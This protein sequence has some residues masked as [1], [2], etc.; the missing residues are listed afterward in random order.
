MGNGKYM[1]YDVYHDTDSAF[2]TEAFLIRIGYQ[3]GAG[4]AG[5]A[6][7]TLRARLP[8]SCNRYIRVKATGSDAGDC[9]SSNF[10]AR[11]LF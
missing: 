6:A 7:A 4:G 3:L 11:L 5:A 9:S 2:G 8:S 10:S 1:Y